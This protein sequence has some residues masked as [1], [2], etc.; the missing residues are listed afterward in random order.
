MK[1]L[2]IT[3]ILHSCISHIIMYHVIVIISF[4]LIVFFFKSWATKSLSH[5][6]SKSLSFN[7]SIYVYVCSNFP[8]EEFNANVH[9]RERVL[10]PSIN[11]LLHN[12]FL[13]FHWFSKCLGL[14]CSH[15]HTNFLSSFSKASTFLSLINHSNYKFHLSL[16]DPF[17]R[18]RKRDHSM[19]V[20]KISILH[21]FLVRR[22]TKASSDSWHSNLR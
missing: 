6:A 3:S 8:F 14:L 9:L 11:L 5:N 21:T 16:I 1:A 10:F 19:F 12:I 7:H 17:E 20:E 18:E 15:P 4:I 13:K 2:S 22:A